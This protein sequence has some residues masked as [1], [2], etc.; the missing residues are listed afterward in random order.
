MVSCLQQQSPQQSPF[1]AC[2]LFKSLKNHGE[3]IVRKPKYSVQM[4]IPANKHRLRIAGSVER[5]PTKNARAFVTDVI[6]IEGPACLKP[7]LNLSLALRCV[8]C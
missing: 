7:Y 3:K 1:F 4:M 8:G 5:A 6:V 2:Y